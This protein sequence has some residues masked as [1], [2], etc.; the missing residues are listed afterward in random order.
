MLVKKINIRVNVILPVV[1][2]KVSRKFFPTFES[3][4]M[5]F[6]GIYENIQ[7]IKVAWGIII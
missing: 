6:E 2:H 5:N 7:N 1:G 3:W 4:E